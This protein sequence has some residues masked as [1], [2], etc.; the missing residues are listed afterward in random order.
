MNNPCGQRLQHD[1]HPWGD[2]N[3]CDGDERVD[4]LVAELEA[5]EK[6]H[7]ILRP[8]QACE[9]ILRVSDDAR[10]AVERALAGT[11]GEKTL[12]AI[13]TRNGFTVGARA[14]NRHR[15]EAHTPT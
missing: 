11:I 5:A 6:A 1:P 3:W 10:E 12:A 4:P 2:L 8:C 9:A 14:I 7:P 13:L 15:R